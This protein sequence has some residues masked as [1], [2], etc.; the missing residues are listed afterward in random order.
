METVGSEKFTLVKKQLR[1][2]D[3]EKIS[4]DKRRNLFGKLLRKKYEVLDEH[5]KEM[6]RDLIVCII[7]N[8]KIKEVLYHEDS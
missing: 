6:I 7:K 3:P 8:K 4:A 5:K 2:K 1:P